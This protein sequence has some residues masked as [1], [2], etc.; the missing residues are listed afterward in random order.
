MNYR[1]IML[2]TLLLL[3]VLTIGAVSAA[4]DVDVVAADDDAGDVIESPVDEEVVA[5]GIEEDVMGD[6]PEEKYNVTMEVTV[7]D[8]VCYDENVQFWISVNG[9]G[10]GEEFDVGGEIEVYSNGEQIDTL[11]V[12]YPNF[13]YF[14]NRFGEHDFRAV[15]TGSEL[16]NPAEITFK[17]NITN[18]MYRISTNYEVEYGSRYFYVY[19]PVLNQS[20]IV[21]TINGKKFNVISDEEM[22]EYYCNASELNFGLN[23]V[24]IYYPGDRK[25]GEYSADA[26]ITVKAPIKSEGSGIWGEPYKYYVNLPKDATGTLSV[27]EIDYNGE[28]GEVYN[29]LG[30]GEAKD[31]VATVVLNDLKVGVNQLFVSFNGSYEVQEEYYSM[32]IS[33]LVN[34]P[35]SMIAGSEEYI[36]VSV[37]ENAN[38]LAEAFYLLSQDYE[39]EGD[40]VVFATAEVVNGQAKIPL[41]SLNK[42]EYSIV[43]N[44][45]YDKVNKDDFDRTWHTMYVV[46]KYD[47]NVNIT[48]VTEKAIKDNPSNYVEFTIARYADGNLTL[49]VDGKA[50]ETTQTEGYDFTRYFYLNTTGLALGEHSLSVNFTSEYQGMSSDSAKFNV[51]SGAIYIPDRMV[52]NNRTHVSANDIEVRVN[53]DA[54]G[55]V[56]ILV[57]GKTYLTEKIDAGATEQTQYVY[58]LAEISREMHNVTVIYDDDRYGIATQ[59]KEVFFGYAISMEGNYLYGEDNIIEVYV[60]SDLGNGELTITV[61]GKIMD[62]VRNSSK[63]T[64]N[65]SR[66]SIG[67]HTV[68]AKYSGDD[69]YPA[70]EFKYVLEVYPEIQ[71]VSNNMLV[72]DD[73]G[74]YLMLPDDAKGKFNVKVIKETEDEEGFM[75]NVVVDSKLVSFENGKAYY[76]FANLSIG[77]Y[78]FEAS[79]TGDDYDV[80]EVSTYI[81]IDCVDWGRYYTN[82]G[83]NKTISFVS[84]EKGPGQLRIVLSI[85]T[86]DDSEFENVYKTVVVP[87]VD[88]RASYSFTSLPAGY[89]HVFATEETLDGEA[90]DFQRGAYFRVQY[91]YG[92]S[93]IENSEI[94]KIEPVSI[95]LPSDANGKATVTVYANYSKGEPDAIKTFEVTVDGTIS[96]DLNEIIAEPG[97]YGYS[98]I[99]NGNYGEFERYFQGFRVSTLPKVAAPEIVIGVEDSVVEGSDLE[100]E[101][102]VEGATGTVRINGEEK[103]LNNS[104]ASATLKNVSVGELLITVDYLGDD[105]YLNST[106]SAKVTVYAKKDAELTATGADITAGDVAIISISISKNATGKITVN[107]E[108]VAVVNGAAKYEVKDLTAGNY[109]YAVAYEGDTYF[110][111]DEKTAMVKVSKAKANINVTVTEK[112]KFGDDVVI[113]ITSP[114]S[115]GKITLTLDKVNYKTPVDS[116]AASVSIPNLKVASYDAFISFEGDA[117]YLAENRTVSFTVF[118][119]PEIQA[120]DTSVQYTANAKYSVTVYGT[121]ANPAPNTEVIFK[122]AGKQVGKA[123]TNS[124]GVAT[125][126]VKNVPGTYKI[127]ATALGKTQ[128]KKLTVKHIVTI[129][130]TKLKKSAKKL[131][132]QATLAKVNGKYLAKKSITFKI[133]GKKVATAKTNSR[134]VAKITIKNPNVVKNAKVGNKMTYQATYL[135]DTVKKTAKILK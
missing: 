117:K 61:D 43:V 65:P 47:I 106:N 16:F 3:A 96:F 119:D 23:T 63:F 31:G 34:L 102:T 77:E 126:T 37:S 90:K 69:F 99:Y 78:N 36:T 32:Y 86:D 33:P 82:L 38:G 132:L 12:E 94:G 41:S 116:G 84:A 74:T 128:T 57:D 60:P 58:S 115:E 73:N 83:D 18:S 92:Q 81:W 21:I 4:G 70:D 121:D 7:Y 8:E 26:N 5:D 129:K 93:S 71:L 49:Y 79:Y 104:K 127:S 14:F 62:F 112:V 91:P 72:G 64:V 101:V 95:E 10:P 100:V 6:V 97:F 124:N 134:G 55:T 107:G 25:F 88:G 45:Y 11:D 29:L 40:Y 19:S 51:V 68:V 13:Y 54:K 15:Y 133:N 87:I 44:Y 9:E 1:K 130:T 35:K 28:D 39:F 59:S 105:R 135:K 89:Y 42:G 56:T 48:Y 2:A 52:L 85:I 131:T 98:V 108:E 76:S 103:L 46:D 109:T 50:V 120:K 30:S 75:V 20:D 80:E 27:Y 123:T 67:N 22:G 53:D 110:K 122:I 111:A 118:T 17:Y 125:Y 24:H 66:L 113:N 114:K